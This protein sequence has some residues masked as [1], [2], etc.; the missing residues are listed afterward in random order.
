MTGPVLAQSELKE[1]KPLSCGF[2][3]LG[4]NVVTVGV[5]GRCFPALADLEITQI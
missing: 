3:I 1:M 4:E 5:G 2:C